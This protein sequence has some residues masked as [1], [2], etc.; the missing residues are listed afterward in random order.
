MTDILTEEQF[1]RLVISLAKSRGDDGFTEED[2]KIV[3]DW[4]AET[5]L[6]QVLLQMVFEERVTVNVVDGEIGFVGMRLKEEYNKK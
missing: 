2:F 5:L 6:N 3:A 4:A 1:E